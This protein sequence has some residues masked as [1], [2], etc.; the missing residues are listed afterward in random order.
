MTSKIKWLLPEG[1]DEILPPR[2]LQIE[3]LRRRLV[4]LF[5]QNSYELIMPPIIE[6]SDTL[7]G[8]AHD[9]LSEVSF[10]FR[11]SL[12]GKNISLRPDI[13]SQASRIDAYRLDSEFN[14]KLAPSTKT[15]NNFWLLFPAVFPVVTVPKLIP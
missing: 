7:G 13:S 6:F 15:L 3:K 10:T 5:T 11:D 12:S 8:E 4:D 2:A 9:E 1:V 14:P